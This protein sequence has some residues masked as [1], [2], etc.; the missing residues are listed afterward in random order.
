MSIPSNPAYTKKQPISTHN[1]KF[2]AEGPKA[3][4]ISIE[5][6]TAGTATIDLLEQTNMGRISQIQGAWIDNVDGPNLILECDV[7]GQTIHIATGMQG[8]LQLLSANP[9]TF[10]LTSDDATVKDV[11]IHFLNFP[12]I[13]SMVNVLGGGGGGIVESIVAGT[14]VS[15]DSTDPANPIVSATGGGGGGGGKFGVV[16]DFGATPAITP[17]IIAANP[18]LLFIFGL[19][20]GTVQGDANA[21]LLG[22]KVTVQNGHPSIPR[23]LTAVSPTNN[24]L[25][26][27][28][29][30]SSTLTVAPGETVQMYM[31][32]DGSNADFQV[33]SRYV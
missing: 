18:D 22:T 8:Y 29:A 1:N 12:V 19:G 30:P 3:L 10:R 33:I 16:T 2:P 14:N 27:T 31:A 7:T 28:A 23:V 15:V 25:D 6:P 13:H 17:A 24:F 9:P 21:S 5:F 11:E 4:P 32:S 26:G 20:D